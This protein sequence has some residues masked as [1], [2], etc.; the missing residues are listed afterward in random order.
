MRRNHRRQPSQI[1]FEQR[2]AEEAD[3]VKADAKAMPRGRKREFLARK[4]R[5]LETASHITEWLLSPGLT[6]PKDERSE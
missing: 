3:R 2:L 1:P 4:A 5:Q 6:K